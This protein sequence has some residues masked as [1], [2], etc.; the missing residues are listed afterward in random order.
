VLAPPL[1]DQ[2][3][4]GGVWKL[5]SQIAHRQCGCGGES[6]AASAPKGMAPPGDDLWPWP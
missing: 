4:E 1:G 6:L 3:R 2:A 5:S